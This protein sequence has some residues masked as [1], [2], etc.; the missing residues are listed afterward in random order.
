M[1]KS[2]D[3][4]LESFSNFLKENK[5]ESTFEKV[6]K[7]NAV[8]VKVANFEEMEILFR[9]RY[10]WA[11]CYEKRYWENYVSKPKR[12]QYVYLDFDKPESFC[13]SAFA[14][15]YDPKINEFTDAANGNDNCCPHEYTLYILEKIFGASEF[16][17]KLICKKW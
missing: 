15:T 14:F 1:K 16:I 3:F 13:G 6:P 10:I 11:I 12:V 5:L 8:I 7:N 2:Y 9:G 4:N 17:N